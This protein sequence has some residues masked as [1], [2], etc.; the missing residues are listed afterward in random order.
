MKKIQTPITMRPRCADQECVLLADPGD[1][2]RH[3]RHRNEG[4]QRRGED[5]PDQ[6]GRIAEN[7][8]RIV[9]LGRLK[10][11]DPGEKDQVGNAQDQQRPVLP[12]GGN[13]FFDRHRL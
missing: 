12:D 8:G 13:G 2:T 4:G 10:P 11:E 9:G 1:E 6:L 7:V 5:H 3:D